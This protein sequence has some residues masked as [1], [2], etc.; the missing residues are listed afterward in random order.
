MMW[1]GLHYMRIALSFSFSDFL[2]RTRARLFVLLTFCG[3]FLTLTASAQDRW[4]FVLGVGTYDNVAIPSLQNAVNDARTIASSLNTM[5]FKV[6]YLENADKSE[7]E[8][9]VAQIGREQANADL[10]MFYFAGHGLQLEGENFALPSDIQVDGNDFLER[11]GVSVNSL[12]AELNDF[13]TQSLVVILDACR[14]SPFQSQ[15]AI[16]TGL[17]LFD[18]PENTIVAYSTAPGAVAL[19]GNSGNSPYTAALATALQGGE[20][21]MRDVLRLV[22]ARVRVATGGL[23]T[24][25]YIDNTKEPIVIRPRFGVAAETL[26]AMVTGRD[27]S[28]STTAWATVVDSANPRDFE[29]FAALF[30]DD[31]LADVARR[32]LAL[33]TSEGVAN[34]PEMSL[35]LASA[36]SALPGG[37]LATITACDILAT[38]VGDTLALVEPVPHDLVNTRAAMRAC[39]GAVRNDPENPRLLGL[40][41]RVLAIEERFEESLFYYREAAERGNPMA[42]TGIATAHRLGMGVEPDLEAAANS[43]RE[44]ALLGSPP[45]RLLLG[46]YFRE[47]WGVEQSFSEARRWIRLAK[48]AGYAPAHVAYG[49][50]YRKGLGVEQSNEEALRHYRTA[51]ALGSS[52]AV[53]LIGRAYMAGTGV[54]QDTQTGIRWLVR[55]SEAGNPYAAN[56]LGHAFRKGAGVDQDLDKALAYFRLS[57][58]RNFVGAY[59]FIGDILRTGTETFAA[60]LPSAYANYIIAREGAILRNTRDSQKQLA[61]AE[62]RIAAI[63]PLMTGDQAAAG[64]RIAQNWIDQYGLLDFNLV[65]E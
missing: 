32:Q 12:I 28:L 19:D 56:E 55:S 48:D 5:G 16:G 3:V 13:G 2:N 7:I 27:I 1:H 61:D 6:Y 10:G 47:G 53:N 23:Q 42:H 59:N 24:P 54:E 37:L 35:R 22:R 36:D 65:N 26:M 18:A 34:I 8:A 60:D 31:A 58:Q 20:R 63:L 9:T 38:G 62:T 50:M 45:A 25:W 4:A 11:H 17:A 33:V 49:G 64:E 21:D 46:V 40:L 39:I 51:A 41:G 30:P 14:N 15:G 52:D 44:A 43:V 57:A 29:Q